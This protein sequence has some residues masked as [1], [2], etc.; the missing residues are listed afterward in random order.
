MNTNKNEMGILVDTLYQ[1]NRKKLKLKI[2]AGKS[3]CQKRIME[4]DIHRPGLALAGFVDMFSFQRIQIFGNTEISYMKKM[5]PKQREEAFKQ[6]FAFDIPCFLVTNSN[7]LSSDFLKL[8]DEY[9]IPVF[10]TPF[11]TTK[12]T[13]I[14]GDF[15]DEKF[16]PR[17]FIHGSLV[18][19]YGIGVLITGRSGI[20]KSEVAL[21]LISRGHRLIVDDVV[22]VCRRMGGLLMGSG[23]KTLR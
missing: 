21:D 12:I 1:K 6:I 15:L 7:R 9:Q 14:L 11:T 8:S 23:N 20:G 18:D 4:R 16:A 13:Q 5:S 22:T 2:L 10:S 17:T 19:V 3:G